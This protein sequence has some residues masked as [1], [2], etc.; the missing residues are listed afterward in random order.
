MVSASRGRQLACLG[1]RQAG[2][3][4]LTGW[5]LPRIANP[6]ALCPPS[7]L[8]S[9]LIIASDTL[10]C[11]IRHWVS[12]SERLRFKVGPTSNCTPSQFELISDCVAAWKDA[13]AKI[14]LCSSRVQ[15]HKTFAELARPPS[16]HTHSLLSPNPSPPFHY[17]PRAS[18]K[19]S[20][21]Y[22]CQVQRFERSWAAALDVAFR[23]NLQPARSKQEEH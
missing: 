1:R 5:P 10:P 11:A 19:W 14:G 22:G 21:V 13:L 2:E 20:F 4:S 17:A 12:I 18:R 3:S 8:R 7:C 16:R 15:K 23:E 9:V 6:G